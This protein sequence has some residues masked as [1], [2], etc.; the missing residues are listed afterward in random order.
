MAQASRGDANQHFARPG[1]LQLQLA[2]HQRLVLGVGFL[3]LCVLK[4]CGLDLAHDQLAALG[5][6]SVSFG[7]QPRTTPSGN[8]F[9]TISE[10]SLSPSP[11]LISSS[12]CSRAKLAAGSCTPVLCPASS[13][14]PMSLRARSVRKVASKLLF[15]AA[16]PMMPGTGY[17]V[18]CAQERPEDPEAICQNTSGSRPS[19]SAS[20][21]PSA[22][23]I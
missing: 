10:Q 9:F 22:L 4:H 1:F 14:S 12:K 18:C 23:A 19:A 21:E 8:R 17:Q 20:W 5:A 3:V 2:D 16:V 7:F 15:A 11:C 13:A 6:D